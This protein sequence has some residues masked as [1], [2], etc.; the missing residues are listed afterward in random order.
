METTLAGGHYAGR[1]YP[2]AMQRHL[3]HAAGDEILRALAGFLLGQVRGDDI[4]CR[5]GGDEF[6]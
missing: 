1:G 2:Q 5:Y 4:A 6:I 3:G